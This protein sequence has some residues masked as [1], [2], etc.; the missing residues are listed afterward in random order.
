[1][2]K[3]LL[4]LFL[5]ITLINIYAQNTEL[6][7]CG[8]D[9]VMRN[10][11][12]RFPHEKAQDDAFNIEISNMIK[13][14]K[15]NAA[16]NKNQ[17]IEIP[18]V[19][20]VVGDGSAIGT[21]NNRSDAQII[22]W[23]NYTNGVFAGNASSGMSPSSAVLPIKFV[24][25]KVDPNCNPTNGINRINASHL[26]G[27]VS[28]GVNT[29]VMPNTVLEDEI[30]SL[31]SWDKSKYYNIYVV[32][33]L[34]SGTGLLNGYAYYPGGSRDHSFMHTNVSTVNA[35]TMAHEFGHGLGL[36]HTHEGYNETTGV[37]P[38]NID[39]TL[40]GDLVCDTEPSKSLYHSSVP[41]FCQTGQINPCTSQVYAGVER[42]IM[43]YTYCF[44]DLFTQGQ[45]TRALAQLYQYR[46]SLIDSPVANTQVINNNVTLTAACTPSS[47]T[48]PVTYSIGI[49][50]VKFG[51]I[52]NSSGFY[53][54]A[55]N[56]YYENF[57]QN[58]CLG[59]SKTT[60]P[61]TS[62]TILTIK[63]GTFNAHSVNAY[64]DYNNDGQFNETTERILNQ[65]NVSPTSTITVS[66]T[67]PA[68]AVTNVPL[69]MRVIGDFNGTNITACATPNY[70][71]VE[72]Y[73]V[74]IDQFLSTSEIKKNE[75][76]I[77]QNE[78]SVIVKSNIEISSIDIYDSS[79][80][81]IFSQ[82]GIRAKDFS[83]PITS[84]N[85]IILVKVKL[86]S[87]EIITKKMK[88]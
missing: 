77:S 88:F 3:K 37:C 24:F 74:V 78:S 50:S 35:Q 73:S 1:M 5:G 82:S 61:L 27:Y 4:T 32:K 43:A 80:R 87:G 56:N 75:T 23:I 7:N 13:S 15:I 41:S 26:P 47:I 65:T 9:E 46:Q 79:G 8:T 40:N 62:P 42:N 72:D 44:R 2:V 6:L 34:A 16:F 84:K 10:H 70:G 63:P 83:T 33:R 22:N 81:I 68:N 57:T 25:A 19:V 28:G 76:L 85:I 58:Y 38:S 59:I 71:Q 45:I 64:I 14:G 54:T 66:V 51:S 30:T 21:V 48:N 18:I 67:P 39:C 53:N 31:G 86:Q 20:H 36:R 11:Y 49:T 29:Q 52:N 60:I 12:A 69:R 55:L 17:I